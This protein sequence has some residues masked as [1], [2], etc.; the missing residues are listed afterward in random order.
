MT[1]WM[2]YWQIKMEG[3]VAV[4]V[5]Q[6]M[7]LRFLKVWK[8]IAKSM[9]LGGTNNSMEREVDLTKHEIQGTETVAKTI[10]QEIQE[11][12]RVQGGNS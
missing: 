2:A 4:K 10:Y 8:D 5:I 12:W 11:H 3:E 6:Q 9:H 7:R 1:G